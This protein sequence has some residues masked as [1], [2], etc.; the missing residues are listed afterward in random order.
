[1]PYPANGLFLTAHERAT[2]FDGHF[3]ASLHG[4]LQG[5]IE[6]KPTEETMSKMKKISQMPT[7]AVPLIALIC[8]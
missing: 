7:I 4:L 8:F 5:K 1:M 3:K 2:V 6:I